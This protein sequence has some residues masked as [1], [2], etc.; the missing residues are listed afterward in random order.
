[1]KKYL[2]SFS[3]EEIMRIRRIDFDNDKKEALIFIKEVII[4]KSNSEN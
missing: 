3:D 1:M 4:K 2:I